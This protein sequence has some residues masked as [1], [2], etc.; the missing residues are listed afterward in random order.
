MTATIH[1]KHTG[2][3]QWYRIDLHLHT[4]GSS[5][6]QEPGITYLDI[7][8][9]AELR[10]LDIIAFTDHNTVAGFRAMRAEIEQLELLERLER[11][12]LEERHRLADYRR[13]LDK[14]LVLPGFEFTATFGFHILG[15]F[16]PDMPVRR[17]EHILLGL[18][19]PPEAIDE[20]SSNVGASSDVM[21][22]YRAINEA[23]GIVIAAHVNTA[24][25]VA[26]RGFDFGG[27]TR[28]AY[29]QDPFLHALEVTDLEYGGRSATARFFDGRHAE[30]PRRMRCVQGS[31]AH[32][33]ARDE[34]N[35]KNLGIG[36]RTTQV[37]LDEC[38]F[39][40][41]REVFRSVDF[42]R[43]RPYRGPMVEVYD[44]VQLAREAGPSA[45]VAFHPVLND[46]ALPAITADVCALANG[47]G[48]TIYVGVSADPVELPKGIEHISRAVD[49]I[50]STLMRAIV[51][52]IPVKIEPMETQ[53]RVV[54]RL[55]VQHG[56]K[57]P[58]AIDGSRIYVRLGT[59][60]TL[61]E[62]DQIVALVVQNFRV[63]EEV[64]VL[65][66]GAMVGT[67]G[68]G[69][70][71]ETSH[72]QRESGQRR[73]QPHS[74]GDSR[75]PNPVSR[76]RASDT[77]RAAPSRTNRPAPIPMEL[78]DSVPL[79][80]DD[81]G[82][83]DDLPPL[84]ESVKLGKVGREVPGTGGI[85]RNGVEI[86]GTETRKGEQYHIMRDLRNGSIVK[87]VTRNS[88]RQLWQYAIIERETHVLD[89]GSIRWV[90]DFG[91]VKRYRRGGSVRYD[92][93]MRDK[94][95]GAIRIFYGVTDSGL[96]GPWLQFAADSI[97]IE[98]E[99]P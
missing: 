16:S 62:R 26:M 22:A 88:A 44:T 69:R 50:R 73:V 72:S 31:D 13:L 5:D 65:A 59:V 30:Y 25:G 54:L 55:Q 70:A 21:A 6:Y 61:A 29:T 84:G 60:T 64:P 47:A 56:E 93:A 12:T 63:T 17:M 37:L 87:N 7:L 91:L 11:A 34:R 48:G 58:Y 90:G 9:R 45:T 39:E 36:D 53:R 78:S 71:T 76:N 82:L 75:N 1:P 27:Q 80:P 86:I 38:T 92:L 97:P 19:I 96:S 32:R 66:E 98:E 68:S 49:S 95:T 46:L 24:H 20:G 89:S 15:V 23:G 3:G 40:A 67:G 10:G 41:L 14:I 35:D 33:L 74:A 2:R 79:P 94:D 43:T 51:P 85:P 77:R 8:R 18:N 42:A 4:P 81:L 57:C 28:I 99:T 83:G 52:S